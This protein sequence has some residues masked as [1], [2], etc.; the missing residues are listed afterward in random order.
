MRVSVYVFLIWAIVLSAIC[1]DC[2]AQ[3]TSAI[4]QVADIPDENSVVAFRGKLFSAQK[5]DVQNH[6]KGIIRTLNIPV[7]KRVEKRETVATI[8]L[9]RSDYLQYMQDVSTDSLY[10]I[11]TQIMSN[12]ADIRDAQ[13]RIEEVRSLI[14]KDLATANDLTSL[15]SELSLLQNEREALLRKKMNEEEDLDDNVKRLRRL[16]GNEVD[17]NTI[18]SSFDVK[19]PISGVIIDVNRDLRPGMKIPKGTNIVTI[20]VLDTLKI[21]ANIFE[22]DARRLRVG[23]DALFTVSAIPDRQFEA[24]V[25][26]LSQTPIAA[27]INQPSYYEVELETSNPDLMLLEGYV[28]QVLVP[29]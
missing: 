19:A 27:D 29:N 23:A 15:H 6:D 9:D 7:G 28:A 21:K 12:D 8:D 3:D 10:D 25:T 26:Y 22:S 4:P 11:E 13:S 5:W 18:P 24:K 2:L 20:G 16:L 1:A 14:D 17:R